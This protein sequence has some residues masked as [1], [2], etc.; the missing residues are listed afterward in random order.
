MIARFALALAVALFLPTLGAQTIVSLSPIK[1]NT[2]YD[3]ASPS[4]N[5]AGVAFFC[6]KTNQNRVR[7]GLIA[8][9]VASAIPA[10][11]VI[12]SATLHLELTQSGPSDLAVSLHRATTNWGEGTSSAGFGGG[13]G[14]AATTNDATWQHTFFPSTFWTNPGGDFL[15]APSAT[16][17]VTSVLDQH[18]WSSPGMVA[19]IQA[20]LASPSTN[21][22]WVLKSPEVETGNSKRF[23][24]REEFFASQRPRLEMS[25]IPYPGSGEDLALTTGINGLP[26]GQAL[27]SA[28]VGAVLSVGIAS[29]MGTYVGDAPILVAQ[30]FTPAAPLVSP[31]G[32]P[33]V[34][35][36]PFAIPGPFVVFDGNATSTTIGPTGLALTLGA[37]PPGLTGLRLILQAICVDGTSANGFFAITDGHELRLL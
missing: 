27:K 23:S 6:G 7:R 37:V 1:D 34:H 13:G 2:L 12:S 14:S 24:S 29:P 4:S 26:N 19:D 11:S 35:L 21:F 3:N 16:T 8:F 33:E 5:G 25:L 18:T 22:G 32:F 31:F 15:S 28:A 20:W 9:D 10:G 36:D 30:F 17:V